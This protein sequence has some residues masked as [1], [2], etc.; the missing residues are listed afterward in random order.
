MV[1]L[2]HSTHPAGKM[3]SVGDPV[4]TYTMRRKGRESH[5]FLVDD[6]RVNKPKNGMMTSKNDHVTYVFYSK[7]FKVKVAKMR[8]SGATQAKRGTY[9]NIDTVNYMFTITTIP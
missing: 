8:L 5:I 6:Q 2:S 3:L 7:Y 9:H 1:F 4:Y